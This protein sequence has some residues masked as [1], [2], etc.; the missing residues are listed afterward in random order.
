MLAQN[1]EPPHFSDS[2]RLMCTR[3]AGAVDIGLI[4]KEKV[5]QIINACFSYDIASRARRQ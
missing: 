1:G 2:R 5:P 3:T 4:G